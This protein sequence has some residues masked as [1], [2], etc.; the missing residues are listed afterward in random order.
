MSKCEQQGHKGLACPW[1]YKQCNNI[2]YNE[3]MI[4]SKSEEQQTKGKRF[5]QCQFKSCGSF[6][7]LENSSSSGSLSSF[8]V[9]NLD[10]GLR[11]IFKREFV[12]MVALVQKSYGPLNN[13]KT[14]VGNF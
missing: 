10:I 3:I 2:V 12:Q 9:D 4:L 11:T 1:I 8:S 13:K 5:M 6:Q 14:M 7:W